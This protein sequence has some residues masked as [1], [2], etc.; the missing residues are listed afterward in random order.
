MLCNFN[1]NNITILHIII[2]ASTRVPSTDKIVSIVSYFGVHFC[3]RV[4]QRVASTCRDIFRFIADLSYIHFFYTCTAINSKSLEFYLSQSLY[5]QYNARESTLNNSIY[6]C[7][8]SSS[9]TR[10][11]CRN[12]H[13]YY[14]CHRHHHCCL[15][16]SAVHSFTFV[17]YSL[18]VL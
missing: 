2:I 7:D 10:C 15:I 13:P 18:C 14:Y 17:F 5:K 12:Y 4:L 9:C 8:I 1:V 16:T 11:T 3:I 6:Q